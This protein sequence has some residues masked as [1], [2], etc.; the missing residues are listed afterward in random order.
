MGS[1]GCERTSSSWQ[2]LLFTLRIAIRAFAPNACI[3]GRARNTSMQQ[4]HTCLQAR[5]ADASKDFTK[6]CMTWLKA[7]ESNRNLAGKKSVSE[8]EMQTDAL[9][10]RWTR[11]TSMAGF[12]LLVHL[13][14]VCGLV[15]LFMHLGL[16]RRIFSGGS[17]VPTARPDCPSRLHHPSPLAHS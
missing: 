5:R 15:H 14:M 17:F 9:K 16:F 10:S 12:E 2:G 7:N 4:Q 3:M 6:G 1:Q 8:H 11:I 13:F